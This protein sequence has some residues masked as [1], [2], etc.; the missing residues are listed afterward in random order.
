MQLGEWSQFVDKG[1]GPIPV[2]DYRLACGEAQS[3]GAL[4]PDGDGYDA[5]GG[6][7]V[8]SFCMCPGTMLCTQR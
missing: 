1:K 4:G 2:A 7:G 3:S 8:Y 6:R 5:S